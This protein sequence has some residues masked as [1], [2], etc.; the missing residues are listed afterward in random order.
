[1]QFLKNFNNQLSIFLCRYLPIMP[2]SY[3]TFGLIVFD[4]V[5]YGIISGGFASQFIWFYIA[6]LL[7][8][9]HK[10]YKFKVGKEECLEFLSGLKYKFEKFEFK[11]DYICCEVH[12]SDGHFK[13]TEV[14]V[15]LQSNHRVLIEEHNIPKLQHIPKSLLTS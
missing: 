8:T 2:L 7:L 10:R 14:I 12:D 1:M 4:F 11:D 13:Y 3:F 9:R 6:V 5:V 15:P